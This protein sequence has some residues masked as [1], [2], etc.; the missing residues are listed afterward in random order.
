MYK[1]TAIFKPYDA[2]G[3]CNLKCTGKGVYII[4]YERKGEKQVV[5]VGKS[6]GDLKA[7]MYR[8]FQ[9]WTDKRHPDNKKQQLYERVTYKNS[10][11]KFDDDKYFC[12]VIFTNNDTQANAL[13]YLLIKKYNPEDNTNKQ[14]MFENFNLS[15][16]KEMYTKREKVA[17]AQE[18]DPF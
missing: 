4:F 13:E 14:L 8:H 7:T 16:I 9:K 5:Y 6:L 17:H 11:G 10:K 2:Q 15:Q 1:E 12:R 3:K 18:K